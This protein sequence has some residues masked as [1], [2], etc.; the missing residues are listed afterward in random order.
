V[1]GAAKACR[2]RTAAA[3]RPLAWQQLIFVALPS[4]GPAVAAY[5][6]VTGLG[7]PPL[8]RRRHALE[9]AEVMDRIFAEHSPGHGS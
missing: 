5:P 8:A 4:R 7:R 6:Q 1:W 9:G 3:M 2:Q